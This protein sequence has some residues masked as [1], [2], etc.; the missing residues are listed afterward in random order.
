M[1]NLCAFV[2][3]VEERTVNQAVSFLH[4]VATLRD[5]LGRYHILVITS[6]NISRIIYGL[7]HIL[8]LSLHV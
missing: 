7:P 1:F 8:K 2:M 5:N 3:G 4:P 6:I